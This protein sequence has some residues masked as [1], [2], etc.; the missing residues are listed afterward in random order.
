MNTTQVFVTVSNRDGRLATWRYGELV[1]AV[2]QLLGDDLP[3]VWTNVEHGNAVISARVPL[4]AIGATARVL[5]QI[6][7]SFDQEAIALTPGQPTIMCG[8]GAEK[9]AAEH[10]LPVVLHL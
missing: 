6:A 10:N 7:A 5:A 8:P 3:G 1:A 4:A 9:W 2:R